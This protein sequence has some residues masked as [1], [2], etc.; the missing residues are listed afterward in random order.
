MRLLQ[1]L[2]EDDFS[3]VEIYNNIPP[4][5]IL[6]HT[7]GA[8]DDEVTFKDIYKKKGKGKDKP[9]YAKL[10]F[11]AAQAKR[12]GIQYFWIDTCCIDKSSSTE[13]SEAIN[14]MFKWYQN[15]SKC[16]V[17]LS[18]VSHKSTDRI[19]IP[20][21]I[22]KSRWFTRGWTLQELLAPE[23]VHFFSMEGR[24]LGD[25]T[26]L[27]HPIHIATRIPAPVLRGFALGFISDEE[28]FSWAEGRQTKREEDA[29][30]CLMGLFHIHMPL[31]YGEEKQNAFRRL[32]EEI[33][34]R[35][36]RNE[37]MKLHR[38]RENADRILSRR[39]KDSMNYDAD[40]YKELLKWLPSYENRIERGRT[41]S[42]SGDQTDHLHQSGPYNSLD[43]DV[44]RKG[45]RLFED[46]AMNSHDGSSMQI[47]SL[48]SQEAK[49]LNV[50]KGDSSIRTIPIETFMQRY[51]NNAG[52]SV[53]SNN[54]PEPSRA[55]YIPPVPG[56]FGG[57]YPSH[58]GSDMI[59]PASYTGAYEPSQIYASHGQIQ[60]GSTDGAHSSVGISSDLPDQII[61]TRD[62]RKHPH[63]TGSVLLEGRSNPQ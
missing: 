48:S 54:G 59:P 37:A 62:Y 17:Y 25:K 10:R 33:A 57:Y 51:R 21:S 38:I 4:Y 44:L 15:S 22:I 61:D 34:R 26:S 12:D 6:S 55:I 24:H 50:N 29:A 56:S 23:K 58:D 27:V 46:R 42:R 5:A 52:C 60:G 35:E 49:D 28:K 40:A 14:S 47:H 36:S 9:G 32:R 16:Y 19:L 11:C 1:A 63:V 2:G 53:E 45:L 30:Y 3:L 7:W 8:D 41:S 39:P 43:V 13:L 18:D 31:L 20:T